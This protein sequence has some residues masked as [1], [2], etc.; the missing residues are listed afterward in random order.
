MVAPIQST[1]AKSTGLANRLSFEGAVDRIA[2]IQVSLRQL[3]AERDAR[4]QAAQQ[5]HAEEIAALEDE[6]KGK[7]ALCEKFAAQHRDTLLTGKAKSLETPLAR[8]GFRTGM[9]K[10]KLLSKWTWDKVLAKLQEVGEEKFVRLKP[11]VD[12]EMILA[13]YADNAVADTTLATYGVRVVQ[14][15]SFFVEP[16]LDG[17]KGGAS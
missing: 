2:E 14:D 8:W 11:E 17:E 15:E 10:L 6:L 12:R 4:I 1:R 7:L 5:H 9:P 13:T 16:K 3:T